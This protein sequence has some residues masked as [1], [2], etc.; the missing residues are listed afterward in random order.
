MLPLTDLD[1]LL[2]EV[3]DLDPAARVA[4]IE[5]RIEDAPTRQRVLGLLDALEGKTFL[6]QPAASLLD[7]ELKPKRRVLLEKYRLLDLIGEGGSSTVWLAERMDGTV[8]QRFAVKYLKASLA[9]SDQRRR[10]VA[11]QKILARLEHPHIARLIDAGFDE[12]AV[13]FIVM[14]Y[15]AGVSITRYAQNLALEARLKLFLDALSAV[16]FA[17]QNLIVHRDLKPANLLVDARGT[18]KLLDFGIAKLLEDRA[19]TDTTARALTPDYAAPEQFRGEAT[20][21]A[22]DV[23]AL[24][25]VLFELLTGKRFRSGTGFSSTMPLKEVLAPSK[26]LRQLAA[27]ER[28]S[29]AQ[30]G[31]SIGRLRGDLDAIVR[32]ALHPEPDRRYASV[33]VFA[34]D[35]RRHLQSLPISAQP[36]SWWYQSRQFVRRHRVA[37]GFATITAAIV[38]AGTAATWVQAERAKAEAARARAVQGFLLAIFDAA[39]PGPQA[40]TVLANRELIERTA[41][42]LDLNLLPE[43]AEIRLALGRVYRKLG[44][45]AQAVD[46]MT[47]AVDELRARGGKVDVPLA[48]AQ[49]GRAL[50]LLE[51]LNFS[52]GAAAAEEAVG[53]FR[54]HPEYGYGLASALHALGANL[55]AL[56]QPASALA[57]LN[58]SIAL[59]ESPAVAEPRLHAR[60]LRERALVQRRLGQMT[61]ALA[62]AERALDLL[63]ARRDEFPRDYR[64]SL[65][66]WGEMLLRAGRIADAE[67][68]LR[69]AIDESARSELN[70]SAVDMANLAEALFERNALSAALKMRRAALKVREAEVGPMHPGLGPYYIDLAKLYATLE[71]PKDAMAAADRAMALYTK[72]YPE[73]DFYRLGMRIDRAAILAAT[74][75][76]IAAE[77]ELSAILPKLDAVGAN[78]AALRAA[79]L[80]LLASIAARRGDWGAALAASTEA[81]SVSAAGDE[82]SPR[83]RLAL[84]LVRAESAW[85]MGQTDQAVLAVQSAQTLAAQVYKADHPLAASADRLAREILVGARKADTIAR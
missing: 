59:A 40:N 1:A 68:N 85:R 23:F 39:E 21:T 77:R 42:Q 83:A 12:H 26:M 31:L 33:A 61:L 65:G 24:G 27:N 43:S 67:E 62:D 49:S 29:L 70:P 11:E 45:S 80:K 72:A 58:E 35:L 7:Q 71:R 34:D 36:D 2:D 13:P 3:L 48:W 20:T 76:L 14:E 52:D 6:D 84:A 53:I 18:V 81:L 64:I 78:D 51:A 16:S 37:I 8:E 10:F 75:S 25:A 63:Q 73:S 28:A 74:G 32:K 15:I 50:A 82:W 56:K 19:R 55:N 69:A 17:H 44:L 41:A 38:V 5:R 47:R 46:Q 4:H 54:R 79:A 9:S 22:T 66:F 30:V 57:A 60:A